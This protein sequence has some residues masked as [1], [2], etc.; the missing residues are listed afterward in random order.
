MYAAQRNLI[1]RKLRQSSL[2]SLLERH[3]K[4]GTVDSYQGKEN[5]IVILSLVRNNALGPTEGGVKK[6]KEGF[7]TTPNRI[8]VA[9]SRAMD[10]LVIVGSRHRW[11]S[12]NPMA[13]LSA[14]FARL[15]EDGS[16]SEISIEDLT[17]ANSDIGKSGLLAATAAAKKG[18]ANGIA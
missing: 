7:L 4:I 5:P 3:V 16:G 1:E 8:N 11:P 6:I 10:R 9:A 2:A 15:V 14:G 13:R 17:G 12:A 18:G